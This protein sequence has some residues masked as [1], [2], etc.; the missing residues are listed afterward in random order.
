M[1]MNDAYYQFLFL[2]F[3]DIP[4]L[5]MTRT[6]ADTAPVWRRVWES[7][8]LVGGRKLLVLTAWSSSLPSSSIDA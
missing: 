5:E 8:N 3:S 7:F 6:L 2:Y 1:K 4:I